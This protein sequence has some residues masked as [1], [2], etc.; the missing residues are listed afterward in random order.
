MSDARSVACD[1]LAAVRGGAYAN[2]TLPRLI[3]EAK[4]DARDAA[5]ATELGYGT[6]RAQGSL[7]AIIATASQRP[8]SQLDAEVL[9]VLRLG[10]YQL[11]RTRVPAHAAV[12]TSVDLIRRRRPRATGLVNAVLRRVSRQGNA[13]WTA[14]V[15][16]EHPELADLMACD[17]PQWIV[18]AYADLLGHDQAISAL[19]DDRPPPIHLAVRPGKASVDDI[20]GQIPGA[21]RLR[22][23]PYGIELPGGDPGRLPAITSGLAQVQDEGSQLV[24]HVAATLPIDGPDELWWDMCAGPGGKAAILAGLADQRGARLIASDRRLHR[25]RLV[26]GSLPPGHLAVV[27]DGRRPPLRSADRI[28]LDAPCTGLGA[29]RRRPEARWHR[30]PEHLGELTILQRQ[31]LR[32]ALDVVRP[33]GIVVY[34]TCSPHRA[35]TLDVIADACAAGALAVDVRAALP[36]IPGLTGPSTVLWP[37]LAGTEAMFIAALRRPH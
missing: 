18:N 9:D 17:H 30:T 36:E 15:I 13:A 22:Y 27:A 35:E 1:L 10:T 3:A 24:A 25:T 20:L 23:S 6:C 7:D 37:Q 16:T 33:G 31:L 34:S 28:L 5:L 4:L 19:A 12:T 21:R 11:L 2:L 29:L 32:S 8:N 14:A 26:A